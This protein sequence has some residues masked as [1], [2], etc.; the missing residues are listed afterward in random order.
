MRYAAAA[1]DAATQKLAFLRSHQTGI[2]QT[3]TVVHFSTR[4]ATLP[5]LKCPSLPRLAIT[6]MSIFSWAM[7][8]RI[9]LAGSPT[10]MCR[11]QRM[12]L[13]SYPIRTVAIR[14]CHANCR[15]G[16]GSTSVRISI[17]DSQLDQNFDRDGSPAFS[18]SLTGAAGGGYGHCITFEISAGG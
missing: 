4:S 9:S 14:G 6:T 2:M 8:L 16:R 7:I 12:S 3:G 10:A 1:R 18:L 13:L 5:K 11:M 15:S 17:P